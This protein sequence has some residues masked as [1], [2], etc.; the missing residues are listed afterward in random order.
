[1]TNCAAAMP[2]RA[3]F[4]GAAL[5]DERLQF[6]AGD[7]Q[8]INPKRG[9]V[10]KKTEQRDKRRGRESQPKARVLQRK[11][12]R[13][14]AQ[15]DPE[16]EQIIQ[17]TPAELKVIQKCRCEKRPEPPSA[18]DN[19]VEPCRGAEDQREDHDEEQLAR[20]LDRH[21]PG[22]QRNDEVA[23]E[24]RQRRPA[25]VVKLVAAGGED[26]KSREMVRVVEQRRDHG[27][28]QRD[29]IERE[30]QQARDQHA[31]RRRSRF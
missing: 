13:G 10:A 7:N 5:S 11:P 21:H 3:P 30:H 17:K 12:Q 31:R 1:M 23:R 15:C 24:V 18:A 27:R 14:A 6:D 22:E 26:R 20:K 29:A 16:A 4:P 2:M 9:D 28:K 8:R 19:T 25:H